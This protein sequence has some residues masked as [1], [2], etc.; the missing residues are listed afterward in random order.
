MKIHQM[1]CVSRTINSQ[2]VL[3]NYNSQSK[4]LCSP[5]LGHGSPV[6]KHGSR[7]EKSKKKNIFSNATR[8]SPPPKIKQ[9]QI[10]K[11]SF[12]MVVFINGNDRLLSDLTPSA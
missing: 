4:Q 2:Y 5:V 11:K 1:N 10:F 6:E 8:C 3:D 9:Q 12:H 7:N